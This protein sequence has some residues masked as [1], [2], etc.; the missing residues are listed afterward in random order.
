MLCL[1]SL[2]VLKMSK[3][4]T[5][6]KRKWCLATHKSWYSYFHPKK[7]IRPK[8]F[9]TEESAHAW[10][11]SQNLKPREYWLKPVKRNGKLQVVK[12]E[13]QNSEA[14]FINKK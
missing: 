5:R 4:H 3:I 12:Y 1:S 2:L 7:R 6:A 14:N 11:Q 8:T 10:A 9:K 13:S